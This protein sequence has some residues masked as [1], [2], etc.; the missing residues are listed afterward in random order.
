LI[1]AAIFAVTSVAFAEGAAEDPMQLALTRADFPAGAERQGAKAIDQKRLAE[2]FPGARGNAYIS[3][4]GQFRRAVERGNVLQAVALGRELG[5][6]SL[7]DSF[8]GCFCS[9]PIRT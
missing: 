2:L 6:L 1:V 7:S 9:S 3:L 5:R 8:C 4:H